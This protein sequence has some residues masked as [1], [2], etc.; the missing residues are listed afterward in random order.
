MS[1]L[2]L[3]YLIIN[4]LTS[5]CS[6]TPSLQGGAPGGKRKD[7]VAYVKYECKRTLL[8]VCI[9]A[10]CV[11]LISGFPEVGRLFCLLI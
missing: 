6:V 8:A 4:I 5:T 3:Y 9:F 2:E 10:T 1:W 11:E 7:T